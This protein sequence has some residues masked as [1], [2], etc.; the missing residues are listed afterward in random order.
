MSLKGAH[1]Y[2]RLRDGLDSVSD[3]LQKSSY[4]Y[5]F[6]YTLFK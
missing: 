1:I 4:V 6:L 3:T 2:V 5:L